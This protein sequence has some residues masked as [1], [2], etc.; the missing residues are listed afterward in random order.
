MWKDVIREESKR[1][2]DLIDFRMNINSAITPDSC[3][4]VNNTVT[5]SHVMAMKASCDKLNRKKRQTSG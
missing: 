4:G 2:T 1:R 5:V 3:Y